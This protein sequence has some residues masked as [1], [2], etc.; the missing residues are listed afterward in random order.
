MQ[1]SP[2]LVSAN[3]PEPG[4][5]VIVRRRPFV[6]L[7]II[8]SG[9]P[10]P[11]TINA[12]V[13][14]QHLVRLLSVDDE[15]LGEELSV[16]WEIEPGATTVEKS[17]LPKLEGFDDPRT[18]DAFL[19]AVTWGAVSSADT[20][21]LQAPF[22]AGVDVSDSEY[23]L[24]PI[25]RA[26]AMPRVNL[27]IADDVGLGK[28][29][30]A[31]LVAQELILRHRARTILIVCPS[32]IQVQW[33][34]EMR[35]KFGLEFRI[36]DSALLSELRRNRGIHA[37]P[38]SH[39]PRLITSVDFLKRERPMRLFRE[40]L[41][42]DDQPRYPRPYDLL[43]VDEAHNVAPSGRGKYATDSQRTAAIRALAPYFEHKLFL[44]ATPHNGYTESFSALLELLD[45][46]RFARAVTPSRAQLN[47]VMVRRMKSELEK[48]WD[49]SRR[50]AE[51]IVKHLEV[52]YTDAEREIHRTLQ[53]YSESRTRTAAT[54]GQ[55]LA[56]EFTLKL[57]KKRLFSSPAAFASTLE[58]HTHSIGA[59]G[60][61]SE[62]I[63]WQ[64][65]LEDAD[66]DFAN[67]EEAEDRRDEALET[68]SRH[69]HPLNAEERVLLTKLRDHA[70]R[71][72]SLPDSKARTLIDW[73]KSNLKP[74][75]Q[76][77]NQRVIIFTEYRTTQKWLH[78]LLAAEGL[79]GDNRLLTIYGGMPLKGAPGQFQDRESIKA[80]FQASPETSQ[81]RILL[82]TDAASEGLN[83]Q[84]HCWQLFH[85]EIPWN[86]NR[87][88]QR[89]GRVDRHGQKNSE[90]HIYH[91]VGRGFTKNRPDEETAPGDL[92]GD[93]EFL[94]RA[95][96]K[97]ETI[98]ED[99][100][101]VGLVI[102]DQV[103]A[104]MLGRWRTLDT[105]HAERDVAAVRQLLKF[106]RQIRDQLKKLAEQLQE[107]QRD[108]HLSPDHIQN[109][110]EVGLA[111]ANQP[112]LRPA[113]LPGIWPDP[114]GKRNRCPVFYLGAFTGSWMHCADGLAH[115]HTKKIRPIVFD[116][117]LATGRDD[118]VLCHLNHRL[119]QMC[120]R[121]LRAEIWS[122]GLNKKLH[123]FTTRLVEDNV[124]QTP[125]AIVHGRLLVIGGDNQRVHEELIIAGGHLREGRFS[126][127]N[128]TEVDAAL[129]A[130]SDQSAPGFVEDR[131]KE[132]WP[133]VE[134]AAISALDARVQDRTK[135]LQKFLDERAEREVAQIT[136]VMTELA[137]SIEATL[138]D[139]GELQLV[140]DFST[141][142]KAQR[143]HDLASLRHRLEQI[144]SEIKRETTHLRDRYRDPQPRLFPL[145]VTILVPRRA[146]TQ[147]VQGGLR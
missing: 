43:I 16:I 48:R 127:M 89:N 27:L 53:T 91:F 79:A 125:A 1:T 138:S 38:W 108:L 8:A 119:V 19:N 146:A 42:A 121:L 28:T 51:R 44:S 136:T 118:V 82:A 52:P 132:L 63:A 94:Y 107:T 104:A 49:G 137:R 96:L 112:P 17:S 116:H 85:N 67:D 24:D 115:P 3:L 126:R 55:R 35:D 83:L 101:K 65:Q 113:E 143:E 117:A 26:L 25:V 87:M 69:A 128:V 58:K 66:E 71:F 144:P 77:N 4:Q 11:A 80:A 68:A 140:L 29:I 145:A 21:A 105:S 39:F 124:L 147:L 33:K 102:A 62:S 97:V 98:R 59:A 46:Q 36:V 5:V 18:F 9:L 129:A 114:T 61:T 31:G 54:V 45:D 131:M 15:G 92:E 142:E 30:E 34:E 70:N 90:V 22:R 133:K 141:E 110:V 2:F 106:E 100:G 23:Q 139:K 73:L 72:G 103:E 93:L 32:S 135:N 123:R 120:M 10:A 99:L 6:V 74:N 20:K 60:A 41:P 75:G 88:E 50:F 130:A 37:N 40:T 12:P 84:N 86:P 13:T 57:L 56:T 109:V 64:R 7:D 111:L 81:V 47:A 78:G 134:A 95:A 14:N 122:Q 76:W